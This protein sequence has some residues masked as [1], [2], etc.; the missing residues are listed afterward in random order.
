MI[1]APLMVGERKAAGLLDMKPAEF[2]RLVD[3][4]VLPRPYTRGGFDRWDVLE[5]VRIWKGDA[6]DGMGEV[7]W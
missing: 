2:L 4:G 7:S 1:S 3:E 6:I 5:L